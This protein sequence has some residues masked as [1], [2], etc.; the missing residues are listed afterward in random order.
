MGGL[1]ESDDSYKDLVKASNG[2]RGTFYTESRCTCVGHVNLYEEPQL[3][4]N[5]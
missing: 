2:Y 1:Y 3:T 4:H 5:M